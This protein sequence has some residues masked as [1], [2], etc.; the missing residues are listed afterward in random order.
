MLISFLFVT[1]GLAKKPTAR[2]DPRKASS[3]NLSF[4]IHA[5]KTREGWIGTFSS[6]SSHS[7]GPIAPDIV[8]SPV[9]AGFPGDAD[10]NIAEHTM[11]TPLPRRITKVTT[12]LPCATI[13]SGRVVCG[14]ALTPDQLQHQ[15][16]PSS[17]GAIPAIQHCCSPKGGIHASK[18]CSALREEIACFV[19]RLN[20]CLDKCCAPRW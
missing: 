2:P 9:R 10:K 14:S 4:Y 1:S 16:I 6:D 11:T 13:H 8:R 20:G 15:P 5:Q 18:G 12:K 3:G 17:A 7:A 19:D